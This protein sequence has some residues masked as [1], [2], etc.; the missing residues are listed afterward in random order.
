MNSTALVQSVASEHRRREGAASEGR[1]CFAS[2]DDC[3]PSPPRQPVRIAAPQ[4]QLA[5][6]RRL[7][8]KLRSD[9]EKVQA[10]VGV[11]R[12]IAERTRTFS[13]AGRWSAGVHMC[14]RVM[15]DATCA[16]G[17]SY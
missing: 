5:D 11:S 17:D 12:H 7:T 10:H 9:V 16:A 13:C 1:C 14:T 6:E 2:R 8:I 3:A 4:A 15:R